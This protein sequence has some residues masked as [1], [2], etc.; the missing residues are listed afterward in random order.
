MTEDDVDDIADAIGKGLKEAYTLDNSVYL[1]DANGDPLNAYKGFSGELN[2][3]VDAP[4]LVCTEHTKKD[5]DDYV[6]AHPELKEPDEDEDD[7]DKDDPT[8]GTSEP[9]EPETSAPDED[10]NDSIWDIFDSIFG[11]NT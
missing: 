10:K 11:G 1:V 4:Y 8:T 7:K 9:T 6:K 2:E 5:W 3:D